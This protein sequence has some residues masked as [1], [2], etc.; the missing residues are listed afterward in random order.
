METSTPAT[1]PPPLSVA[2]PVIVTV[3]P[4]ATVAPAAGEVIVEVG[5][6]VSVDARGARSA[7]LIERRAAARP[8]RRTG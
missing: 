2:V 5:A 7:R 4:S 1:T 6:V 3:V 8:C